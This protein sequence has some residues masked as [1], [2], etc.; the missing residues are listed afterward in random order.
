ML[1]LNGDASGAM[2]H[3][4]TLL[5]SISSAAVDAGPAAK[6]HGRLIVACAKV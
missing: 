6:G 4:T 2:P 5:R 3:H 1:L